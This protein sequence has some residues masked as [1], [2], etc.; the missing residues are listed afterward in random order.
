MAFVPGTPLGKNFARR[1][2]CIYKLDPLAFT[3]PIEPIAD[4]VPGITPLRVT[5]DLVDSKTIDLS[6][7][8]T[9]NSIQAGS[10]VTANVHKNLERLTVTGTMIPIPF[11]PAPPAPIPIQPANPGGIIR[12][13]RLRL[14]NLQMMADARKPVMVTTPDFAL[15]RAFIE[16]INSPR[17]PSDGDV[18]IVTIDFIECRL[19]SPVAGNQIVPDFDAQL[20]GGNQTTGGGQQA[21]QTVTG[22]TATPSQTIGVP[23]NVGV[24]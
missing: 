1:T 23:P 11:P 14:S 17:T 20:P 2:V 16:R 10:D 19:V 4:I 18:S 22:T 3:V 7:D 8:V 24:L 21:T 9:Q 13:D 12:L 6:Y 15:G 5:L